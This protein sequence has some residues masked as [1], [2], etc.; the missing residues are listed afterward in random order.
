MF[1]RKKLVHLQSTSD[2]LPQTDGDGPGQPGLGG[3]QVTGALLH[4][5]LAS[6]V[7][8]KGGIV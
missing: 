8:N 1:P 5:A 4:T 2:T 6:S 7:L 3:A